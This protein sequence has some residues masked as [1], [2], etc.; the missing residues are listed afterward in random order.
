MYTEKLTMSAGVS[1]NILFISNVRMLETRVL[2]W[3]LRSNFVDARAG[4][5][6]NKVHLKFT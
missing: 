2:F 1:L 3:N 4:M 6:D 5:W